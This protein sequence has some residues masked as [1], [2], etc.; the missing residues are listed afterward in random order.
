VNQAKKMG[1]MNPPNTST[2]FRQNLPAG[3]S[4]RLLAVIFGEARIV[5]CKPLSGKP[6]G[7][8]RAR[9]EGCFDSYR[10]QKWAFSPASAC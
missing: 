8:R 10:R 7:R 6:P 4:V 9:I 3:D 2:P 1:R 5:L